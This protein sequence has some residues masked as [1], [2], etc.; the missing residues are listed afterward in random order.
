MRKIRIAGIP[1]GKIT[2]GSVRIRYYTFLSALDK[3]KFEIVEDCNNADIFYVQKN[4]RKEIIKLVKK[5]KK[6]GVKIVYDLDDGDGYRDKKDRD[7]KAMFALSDAATTDTEMRAGAFRKKIDKPVI[8][9]Q[10]CID[11]GI[12]PGDRIEIREKIIRGGTFG[13]HKVLE[14]T[15]NKMGY[16]FSHIE[17]E[18]I[19]DRKLPGCDSWKWIKW[20]LGTF[21]DT[22][23]KWDVCVLAHPENDIGGMKSNNRLLVCMALGIPTFASDTSAYAETMKA[24]GCGWLTMKD[25]GLWVVASLFDPIIRKSVS[26]KMHAYAW[27]NYS[28]EISGKQLAKVFRSVL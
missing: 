7:D 20:H 27:E 23:K 9:V 13:T 16:F 3:S 12:R 17:R 4:S 18:Y 6:K 1:T 24:A 19:T 15:F 2:G 22:I 8:V 10:D 21:V 5:L 14:A 26:N 25:K 28:P 11:Y